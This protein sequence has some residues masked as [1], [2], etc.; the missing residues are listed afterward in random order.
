MFQLNRMSF[1]V[2]PPPTNRTPYQPP[3]ILDIVAYNS[4]PCTCWFHTPPGGSIN[5]RLLHRGKYLCF[6][7]FHFYRDHLE[8]HLCNEFGQPEVDG[9]HPRDVLRGSKLIGSITKERL[10]V[11]E[12]RSDVG[13]VNTHT[14]FMVPKHSGKSLSSLRLQ[15]NDNN[16]IVVAV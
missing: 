14:Q 13:M 12:N 11:M 2:I 5:T 10:T 16:M 6:R 1:S 7:D 15:G 8:Y 3:R 4:A 9:G